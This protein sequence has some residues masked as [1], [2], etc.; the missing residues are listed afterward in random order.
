MVLCVRKAGIKDGLY[1]DISCIFEKM[2]LKTFTI[3]KKSILW[4]ALL[5]TGTIAYSQNVGVGTVTPQSRLEVQGAGN[6]S[7]T[8]T[9]N[10]TNSSGN[11]ALFVRDDQKVGINTTTPAASAVLDVNSTQAG[12][13]VPRMTTTQMNAIASPANGLLVYNST[14]NRFY[15]YNGVQWV[16]MVSTTGS[17][18]TT[19]GDPT[20]VYTVDGF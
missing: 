13:L 19:G 16:A 11:S 8:S 2:L 6:T 7:G 17:S 3:M 18:S 9:L 20:L 10:V 14:D 12:V 4:A 15:Y 1:V 5:C